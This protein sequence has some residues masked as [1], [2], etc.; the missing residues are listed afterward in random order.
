MAKGKMMGKKVIVGG[1]ATYRPM[2]KSVLHHSHTRTVPERGWKTENVSS[3]TWGLLSSRRNAII[4]ESSYR[5]IEHLHN[6]TYIH[7]YT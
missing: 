5:A 4:I 2:V 7:M 6:Q 1:R 3:F